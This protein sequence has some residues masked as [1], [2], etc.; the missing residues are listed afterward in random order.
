MTHGGPYVPSFHTDQSA[1][2]EEHGT[3]NMLEDQPPEDTC[4]LELNC[5]F[6]AVLEGASV[7]SCHVVAVSLATRMRV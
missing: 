6:E 5:D 1:G 4:T 7:V 2:K 3:W